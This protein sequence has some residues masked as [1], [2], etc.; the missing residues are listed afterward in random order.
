MNDVGGLDKVYKY[1]MD[2]TF[3]GRWNIDPINSNPT[4]IT[5]D[6]TGASSDIWIV[7]A[8]SLSVYQYNGGAIR[9]GGSAVADAIFS[10]DPT[11]VNPQGIA[12][13][14]GTPA[15]GAAVA[16]EQAAAAL[17]ASLPKD[18]DAKLPAFD[19]ELAIDYPDLFT[20]RSDRR[21]FDN[22]LWDAESDYRMV[23]DA[24]ESVMAELS[25]DE[26]AS[27]ADKLGPLV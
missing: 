6:P 9:T 2:G 10:L 8:T 7:D 18:K 23:F 17:D 24:V 26:S 15:T 3:V 14:P 19:G 1:T 27:A 4:G 5:I 22:P 25:G 16:S 11:N 20:E 12:D 21:R 13:P